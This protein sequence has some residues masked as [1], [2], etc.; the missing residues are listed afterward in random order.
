MNITINLNKFHV[1]AHNVTCYANHFVLSGIID[2]F[3]VP[4]MIYNFLQIEVTPKTKK[5]EEKT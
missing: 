2:D 4:A 1:N 5:P 3:H